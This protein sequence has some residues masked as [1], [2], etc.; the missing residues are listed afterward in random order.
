MEQFENF[1]KSRK[2]MV[3]DHNE[4]LNLVNIFNDM[5]L[6]EI[7]KIDTALWKVWKN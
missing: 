6:D 1:S 2:L 3:Y 7:R 5:F 4:F